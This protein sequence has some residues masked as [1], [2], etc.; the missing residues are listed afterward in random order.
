MAAMDS[1]LYLP[2]ETL[3]F[4]NYPEIRPILSDIQSVITYASEVYTAVTDYTNGN[5]TMINLD[6]AELQASIDLCRSIC[7]TLGTASNV[8]YDLLV[9]LRSILSVFQTLM[10]VNSRYKGQYIKSLISTS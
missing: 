8:C 9:E 2:N 3:Y 6:V 10:Y 5:T 7:Q 4:R 1:T